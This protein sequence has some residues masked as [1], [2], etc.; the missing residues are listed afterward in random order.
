MTAE[1]AILNKYGVA[2]ATDSAVTISAG[3]KEEKIFDTADK[4]FE[5]STKDPIGVMI[6]NNMNFAEIPIPILIK[7][8]R[9]TCD[10]F[11]NISEAAISFLTFL[12]EFA[13]TAPE[14][15]AVAQVTRAVELIFRSISE[16]FSKK[17]EE[18]FRKLTPGTMNAE[19]LKASIAKMLDEIID[20]YYRIYSNRKNAKFIGDGSIKLSRSTKNIITNLIST[21]FPNL[22]DEQKKKLNK[23]GKMICIKDL[24]SASRTGIIVAGYGKNERFPTLVAYEIDGFFEGRLK[25]T[26]FDSIDI[27]RGGPRARVIPFA[28]KEMVERFLYG[29]DEANRRKITQFCKTTIPTIRDSI[30]EKLDFKDEDEKN[31]LLKMVEAAEEAFVNGLNDTAFE[32]IRSQSRSEI[33]DMV[34]FMPKPELAKMAEALVNLTSIKRRVSRGMETVGGAIDVALISRSDGFVWIKRKHYF[35]AELNPRYHERIKVQ[36]QSDTGG[37]HVE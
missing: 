33:E 34:E 4:L 6:Y 7:E 17:I 9:S 1:I 31:G 3:S 20:T 15:V 24:L 19:G 10:G 28:Q 21:T 18:F 27:D 8:F 36:M 35:P 22:T 32:E 13:R 30:I 12:S 16:R 11:D 5:L 14:Q 2:L 29:I 23:I 26:E 37:S 25:Y